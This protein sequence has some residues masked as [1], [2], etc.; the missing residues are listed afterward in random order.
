VIQILQIM[1]YESDLN[2]SFLS[3]DTCHK[4]NQNEHPTTEVLS[5]TPPGSA[6]HQR[7]GTPLGLAPT[8]STTESAYEVPTVIPHTP[9]TSLLYL[10]YIWWSFA[11]AAVCI[12]DW[13][14]GNNTFSNVTLQMLFILFI[15]CINALG[16]IDETDGTQSWHCQPSIIATAVLFY[17]IMIH[18]TLH[19]EDEYLRKTFGFYVAIHYTLDLF[20]SSDIHCAIHGILICTFAALSFYVGFTVYESVAIVLTMISPRIVRVGICTGCAL[21]LLL[22]S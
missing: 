13:Y 11:A 2:P 9:L 21:A 18:E 14:M 16:Y 8:T 15:T 3:N 7:R 5:T 4:P 19:G 6:P 20:H 22:A 1:Y 10:V 12:Y 17:Y